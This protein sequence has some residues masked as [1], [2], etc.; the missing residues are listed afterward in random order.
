MRKPLWRTGTRRTPF[1]WRGLLREGFTTAGI[2][3]YFD[4]GHKPTIQ[5]RQIAVKICGNAASVTC[6]L[7]CTFISPDGTTE[8]G[9]WRYAEM[10]VRQNGVWLGFH[11]HWSLLTAEHS[12]TKP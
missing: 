11:C 12:I 4:A 2:K 7:P 8:K 10:L 6:Y 1:S 5:I 3:A 9:T